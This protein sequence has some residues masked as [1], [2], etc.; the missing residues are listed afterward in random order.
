[1]LSVD[2]GDSLPIVGRHPGQA[3]M[4]DHQ[5]IRKGNIWASLFVFGAG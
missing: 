4:A 1:M 2:W 3:D 5:R